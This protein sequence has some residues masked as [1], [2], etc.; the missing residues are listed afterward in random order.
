MAELSEFL[1]V[2]HAGPLLSIQDLGRAQVQHLGFSESGAVDEHAHRWAN[3][4][5]K[6]SPLAASIEITLG[7]SQFIASTD[8]LIA[9]CGADCQA[10]INQQP[11]RNW[12]CHILKAGYLLRFNMPINGLRTYL[13]IK[14]GLQTPVWHNSRATTLKEHIGGLSGDKLTVNN[15]LP[16]ALQPTPLTHSHL[17][18]VPAQYQPDYSKPLILRFIASAFY[19]SLSKY[20]QLLFGQTLYKIAADSNRMG[21]RLTG[22]TLGIAEQSII[23]TPT[24]YGSI[25]L[26]GDGQPIV[27]LKD[28]Q[29]IGGYPVLGVVIK[30]DL[31]SLSQLRPGQGVQF[32]PIDLNTAQQSFI[33]FQNFFKD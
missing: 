26:P 10:T 25:Q 14:G 23:S 6:N 7:Q 9:I 30:A 18:K 5:L 22:N 24:N 31:F 28:R 13:A 11:V 20:K 29:T 16:I 3:K 32:K 33:K 4:L 19:L 27:L 17:F 1:Q 12:S 2:Q 15:K 21:Y 8:C